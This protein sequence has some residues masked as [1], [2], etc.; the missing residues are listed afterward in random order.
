MQ[1]LI[2]PLAI[3]V[4]AFVGVL[5]AVG[6]LHSEIEKRTGYRPFTRRKL[7]LLSFA[8][9]LYYA[10][11]YLENRTDHLVAYPWAFFAMLA[12]VGAIAVHQLAQNFRKAGPIWG[13]VVTAIQAI[14]LFFV[15]PAAIGLLAVLVFRGLTKGRHGAVVSSPA[16]QP[17]FVYINNTQY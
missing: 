4:A 5:T 6:L 9:T 17:Q 2:W 1:D 15:G 11:F 8:A 13:S 7:T 14:V 16:P 3:G 10:A 12:L